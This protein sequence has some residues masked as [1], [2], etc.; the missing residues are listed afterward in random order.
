MLRC[1]HQN[2]LFD[3]PVV[4]RWKV[5]TRF[6]KSTTWEQ[7]QVCVR[8]LKRLAGTQ[9]QHEPSHGVYLHISSNP[10][11]GR[12][13]SRVPSPCQGQPLSPALRSWPQAGAVRRQTR[14]TGLL[15]EQ[16]DK[17]TS[18]AGGLQVILSLSLCELTHHVHRA[19]SGTYW[20]NWPS[21]TIIQ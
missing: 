19:K 11:T 13:A 21:F 1:W 2:L 5:Q 17:C 16:G 4:T 20:E 7:G 10:L 3:E 12:K 18:G 6:P 8:S 9:I 15:S 14:K